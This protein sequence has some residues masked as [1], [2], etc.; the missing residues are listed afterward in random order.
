MRDTIDNSDQREKMEERQTQRREEHA[1][2][3]KATS[4]YNEAAEQSRRQTIEYNRLKKL[5]DK[6]EADMALE[7]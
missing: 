1:T 4:E 3:A 5:L 2:L 6:S 7:G